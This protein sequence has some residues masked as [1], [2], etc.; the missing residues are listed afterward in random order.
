MI[1]IELLDSLQKVGEETDTTWYEGI[2]P[3]IGK[4]IRINGD[5]HPPLALI[6]C[7]VYKWDYTAREWKHEK[8]LSGLSSIW[9]YELKFDVYSYYAGA[10]GVEGWWAFISTKRIRGEQSKWAML[11]VVR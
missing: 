11:H 6:D 10:W 7:Y 5:I 4:T 2:A 8:T 9:D 1:T 3:V